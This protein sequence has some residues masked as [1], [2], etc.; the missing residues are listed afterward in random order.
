[1]SGVAR[2]FGRGLI[3][4]RAS[5]VAIQSSLEG[6]LTDYQVPLVWG[7]TTT[8][9]L[10]SRVQ[11]TPGLVNITYRHPS[12][13][14]DQTGLHQRMASIIEVERGITALTGPATTFALLIPS[15]M[16]AGVGEGHW[17][18]GGGLVTVNYGNPSYIAAVGGIERVTMPRFAHEYAH[19]LFR[20]FWEHFEGND[21]ALNEGWADAL[22]YVSG[23]LPIEEF[24]PTG[25]RGQNFD[26]GCIGV[27]EIHD[28]G[29]C[30][31]WALHREGLLTPVT[32]R[33]LAHVTGTYHTPDWGD[34]GLPATGQAWRA[35]L[36]EVTGQSPST[37][38]TVMRRIERRR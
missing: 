17:S 29:N 2:A 9:P 16:V 5:S 8:I 4:S 19:E 32:L 35:L 38:E 30:V 1:Q 31:F 18:F 37:I 28:A 33:N 15:E 6:Q 7:G 11:D 25:V 20:E 36:A 12:Y 23:A 24:G 3:V 27:A 10:V 13:S 14:I 22:A 21:A 34:A 26:E